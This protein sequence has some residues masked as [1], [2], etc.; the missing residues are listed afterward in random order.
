MTVMPVV[1]RTTTNWRD[2]RP[3]AIRQQGPTIRPVR[4]PSQPDDQRVVLDARRSNSFG[5]PPNQTVVG[6]QYR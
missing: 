4:A 3:R 5:R 6:A 1:D 2:S